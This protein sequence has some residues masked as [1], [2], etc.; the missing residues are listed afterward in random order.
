MPTIEFKSRENHE[1]LKQEIPEKLLQQRREMTL[2]EKYYRRKNTPW[3]Q[4]NIRNMYGQYK[5]NVKET[6][7]E[8]GVSRKSIQ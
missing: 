4:G 5:G 1:K 3:I 6:K 7:G 8:P 2:V